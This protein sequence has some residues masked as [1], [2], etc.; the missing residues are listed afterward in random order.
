ML[1]SALLAP[2]W[3]LS[4]S[5]SQAPFL[6]I[7]IRSL[8]EMRSTFT[9]DLANDLPSI[10]TCTTSS[11]R[12]VQAGKRVPQLPG[13]SLGNPNGEM[14]IYYIQPPSG[15][16][17]V[18]KK[19]FRMIADDPFVRSF[20]PANPDARSMTFLCLD[21]KGGD[22]ALCWRDSFPNQSPDWTLTL[23]TISHVAYPV[24]G[25]CPSTHPVQIPQLFVEINWD[26]TQFNSMW[27]SNGEQPS[28]WSMGDPTGPG[29][30]AD[31]IFGW[32]GDALQRAMNQ[33]TD[34]GGTCPTLLT[35]LNRPST[36]LILL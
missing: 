20:N 29:Q 27:P 16:F 14:T 18:F 35:Q 36:V 30:H 5:I 8:V 23:P 15:S 28:V 34:F 32:Q 19:G 3:S 4:A 12:N 6:V 13:Q 33:C 26:T 10:S 24:N 31:Y 17:Q 25:A 21:A 11:E 1:Y 22:G 2:S 9:M 7:C